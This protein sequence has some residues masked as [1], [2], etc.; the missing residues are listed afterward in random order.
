MLKLLKNMMTGIE[1]VDEQ[2]QELINRIN[3]VIALEKTDEFK[4]EIE[5]A[6][7]FLTQHMLKH[8][9]TEEDYMRKCSYP[10]YYLHMGEHAD[11]VE[12]FQM[13][14]AR[15]KKSGY[16][17]ELA[18]KLNSFVVSWIINHIAT[19]DAAFGRYYLSK[20]SANSNEIKIGDRNFMLRTM[21]SEKILACEIEY[22]KCFSKATEA[23]GL[24]R[25][26]DD[27][28]QDMYYHNF[29]LVMDSNSDDELYHL[30]EGEISLR[31]GSD[32]CNI[33]SFAPIS[34]C[35]LRKFEN[36]PQVSVSGFYLL[37]VDRHSKPDGKEGCVIS[38]V[39]DVNMIDDIV[40]MDL[41]HDEDSLGV[42]FCTR[43]ARRRGKVYLLDE[44]V[45]SYIFYAGGEAVGSC[46]LFINGDVAKIEDF[47]V[48]PTKQRQGYGTLIL[49]S[50]IE[51]ALN[52]GASDI[53]LIASEDD[54]PKEM[55]LKYGFKKI[56]EQT[57]L[58]FK[59]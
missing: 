40:R 55:Y 43:R 29:T 36:K 49:G 17:L 13:L 9:S 32:F 41:E 44:G 42:D 56:G 21:C 12:K 8:F 20:I 48:S 57:D 11:F 22:T 3:A 37:D 50:V 26:R 16:S 33:V 14:K 23:Q 47:A 1:E 30:I 10:M 7:D 45:D 39:N 46:N 35:L 2:H 59:L 25:F 31:K 5:R 58:L 54:T 18:T 4:S 51:T 52:S 24:V 27:L 34:D 53:Y 6:L 28:L 15:Y 38:K 19:S